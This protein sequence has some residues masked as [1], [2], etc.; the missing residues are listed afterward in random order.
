M[1]WRN[2]IVYSAIIYI[3]IV[4]MAEYMIVF[5]H[6]YDKNT[7]YGGI[8]LLFIADS[9]HVGFFGRLIYHA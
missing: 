6:K 2:I 3:F 1:I 7:T 5:R 4:L 8:R 9:L